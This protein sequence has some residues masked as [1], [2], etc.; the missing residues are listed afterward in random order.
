MVDACIEASLV[1]L[2]MG[3]RRGPV[4]NAVYWNLNQIKYN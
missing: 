1:R 4:M 3:R 2:N